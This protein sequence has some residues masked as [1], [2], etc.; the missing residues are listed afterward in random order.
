MPA[1]GGFAT[2]A[3]GAASEK[4]FKRSVPMD[5]MT[6][7]WRENTTSPCGF[8][9]PQAILRVGEL[10]DHATRI[11][12]RILPSTTCARSAGV[13]GALKSAVRLDAETRMSLG[14]RLRR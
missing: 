12:F 1:D 11:L 9:R 13:E 3:D 5:L 2:I 6:L 14:R 8:L 10:R 4:K 7:R